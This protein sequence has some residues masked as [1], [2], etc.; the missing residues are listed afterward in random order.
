MNRKTDHT[1][2]HYW[3]TGAYNLLQ[4]IFDRSRLHNSPF[5]ILPAYNTVY[6]R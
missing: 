1:L 3:G 6:N 2:L 5:C 4:G